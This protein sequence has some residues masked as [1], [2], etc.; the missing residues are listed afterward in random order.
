M[1]PGALLLEINGQVPE[2]PMVFLEQVR[3]APAGE[4]ARVRY[5]QD[6][7][8]HSIEI[9]SDARSPPRVPAGPQVAL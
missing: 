8:T 3:D 9:P 7:A 1:R 2:S 5:W 4:D 6:G